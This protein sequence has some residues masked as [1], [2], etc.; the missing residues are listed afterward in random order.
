MSSVHDK[1]EIRYIHFNECLHIA[2]TAFMDFCEPLVVAVRLLHTLINATNHRTLCLLCLLLLSF[3]M[4]H[5][6]TSR[7]VQNKLTLFIYLWIL[8]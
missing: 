4:K 5:H 1:A 3:R 6:V 7:K 2:N 8:K